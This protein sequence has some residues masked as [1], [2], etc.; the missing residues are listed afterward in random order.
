V[1]PDPAPLG[2]GD[3]QEWTLEGFVLGPDGSPAPGVV[4]TSSAGGSTI[5][6]VAGSYRLEVEVPVTATSMEITAASSTG[7]SSFASTSVMLSGAAGTLRVSPLAL[8]LGASCSPSWLPTFGGEPG[9]E[10][11][12]T[13]SERVDALLVYDDGG[14]PALYAGGLF[15]VTCGVVARNIAKRDGTRWS[16]LGSGVVAPQLR[17]SRQ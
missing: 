11:G 9:I 7:R 5:T 16:A 4:V 17:G 2:R 1:P 10:D 12:I 6:D 8:A 14:G 15:D 3:T 13:T